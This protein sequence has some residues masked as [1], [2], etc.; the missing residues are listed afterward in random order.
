MRENGPFRLNPERLQFFMLIYSRST[1]YLYEMILCRIHSKFYEFSERF[2]FFPSEEKRILSI[3]L[4]IVKL[5]D[6]F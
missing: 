3:F 1:F 4:R 2:N 6:I 5:V